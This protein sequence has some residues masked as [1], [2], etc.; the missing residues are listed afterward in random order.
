MDERTPFYDLETAARL[1]A[2]IFVNYDLS[3][4][5]LDPN[6]ADMSE[7]IAD[8]HMAQTAAKDILAHLHPPT[9]PTASANAAANAA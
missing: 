4:F 2:E 7:S 1:L 3:T 9:P 5:I 6:A 8:Y